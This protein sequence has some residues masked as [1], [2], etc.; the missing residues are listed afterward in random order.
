MS[1]W[2]DDKRL[3]AAILHDRPT[4]RKWL[5]GFLIFDLALMVVGLWLLDDWLGDS[6]V[7]FMIWWG[8]CGL[9]TL[10]V[11]LFALFDALSVMKEK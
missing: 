3:A 6:W 7:R 9:W 1:L 11:L 5:A 4:R 2:E 10:W 8:G